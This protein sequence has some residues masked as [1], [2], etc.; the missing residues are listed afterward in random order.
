M[1]SVLVFDDIFEFL[2]R[3][4]ASSGYR[5]RCLFRLAMAEEARQPIGGNFRERCCLIA[6]A[7]Q[8]FCLEDTEVETF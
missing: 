3:R 5:T 6:P 8:L 2:V 4:T 1:G 7:S